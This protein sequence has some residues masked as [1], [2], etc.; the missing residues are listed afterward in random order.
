MR[1]ATLSR[2]VFDGL[3]DAAEAEGIPYTLEATGRST[4]TDADAVVVSRAGVAAASI[5][6]P[7]RYMH[8]AVEMVALEDVLNTAKLCARVRPPDW[9]DARRS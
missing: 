7:C 1:G 8:S 9:L 4:G 3:V 5:G 6:V 2:K